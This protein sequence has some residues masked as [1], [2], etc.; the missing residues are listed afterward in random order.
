MNFFYN[1]AS[2]NHKI[3]EEYQTRK[4]M[5]NEAGKAGLALGAVSAIYLLA[6]QTM[7]KA[8]LNAFLTMAVNSILWVAKF[9]GCIWIMRTFMK[10][11][12]ADNPEADN[13]A[14]RRF[15]TIAALLSAIVYAAVSFA[16]VA[17]ISADMYKEQIDLMIQ[18]LAPI[19][20]SNAM[21]Q[22]DKTLQSLPQIT[23]FSN[24][25]YCFIYGTILS[26]ILSSNIPSRDP[27]A[28]Y[29][30]EDQQ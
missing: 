26:A 4:N 22:M 2:L 12:A 18:Q 27:F 19:M 6:T 24:L 13:R 5:W 10:N 17:F 29:K 21:Q 11:F 30:P 23:F 25:I 1:F 28:D 16:D 3:M 15:G 14:T 8:E 9:V 20:D 7:A